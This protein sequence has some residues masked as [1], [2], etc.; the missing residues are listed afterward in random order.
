MAVF[1]DLIVPYELGIKV[2]GSIRL[3]PPSSEHWFGTD[4]LGRDVF[5]RI[6]HGSRVSLTIGIATTLISVVIGGFLGAAA[7]YYGGK[8]DNIIMRL[9]D[10]FMCIPSILLALA[11]VAALGPGLRNL[12]IAITISYVPVFTRMVRAV[13]LNVVDQDFVEAAR[14]YGASDMRIILKYIAPNAMGPI[15]VQCTMGIAGM[16]LSAASLSYIGMGIQPPEPEWG[17][18]LS[19][20]REFMRTAP[21]L[22]YFAGF[23][24]LL[25]ALAF[26]LVGDGLRDALDPKL[27]D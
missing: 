15:I 4:N 3:Q 9:V 11:I 2:D 8:A 6:V 5:S 10:I 24:I 17:A 20:A 21:Y 14:A 23:S 16:I 1:A 26:N 25:A 12:L 7:G 27:K 18:M 19:D 13:I 22:I